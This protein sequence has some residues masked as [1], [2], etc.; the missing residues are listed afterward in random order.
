MTFFRRN[1]VADFGIAPDGAELI[2]IRGESPFAGLKLTVAAIAEVLRL[3][4]ARFYGGR[5]ADL[6]GAEVK[7]RFGHSI[8]TAMERYVQPIE[9]KLSEKAGL[10][11]L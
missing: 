8:K 4:A 7:A 11:A 5:R 6:H 10:G 2:N 3:H 1:N 9:S